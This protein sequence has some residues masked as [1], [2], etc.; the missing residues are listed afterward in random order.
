LNPY[1]LPYLPSSSIKGVLR[2]AAEELE[3]AAVVNKLFG[4]NAAEGSQGVLNFWDV[5]PQGKLALD[6]M[7]PHY[8]DYYQGKASPHDSG[9]PNPIVFLTVA[10]EAQF[11][12]HVQL[13]R[14]IEIDMPDWQAVLGKCFDRAFDWLGF[15]AKTAVGYGAMMPDKKARNHAEVLRETILEK[16]KKA[17]DE[18]VRMAQLE[19]MSPSQREIERCVGT[20][21]GAF[22]MIWRNTCQ[23]MQRLSRK[24]ANIYM[25][26]W[27]KNIRGLW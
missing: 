11:A 12:F 4:S 3:C 21:M 9:Q 17:Q 22:L 5:F 20:I 18:T 27:R 26:G 10:P 25:V 6:I 19:A 7:T 14:S 8:G 15:G 1:G 13:I 23:I 16:A 24:F 2:R